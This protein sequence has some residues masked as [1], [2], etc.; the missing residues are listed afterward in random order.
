[1]TRNGSAT[2]QVAINPVNGYNGQVT[3][4]VSGY[5][6]GVTPTWSQ[7]AATTGSTLT[8]TGTNA[9]LGSYTLTIKGTDGTNTHTTSATLKVTKK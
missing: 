4:S 3:L 5:G 2:Y 1:M 7:D 9:A 6:S 8:L